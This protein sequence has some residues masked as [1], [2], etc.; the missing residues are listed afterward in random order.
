M[1]QIIHIRND[2]CSKFLKKITVFWYMI[3]SG[4]TI[5]TNISEEHAISNYTKM[6]QVPSNCC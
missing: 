2:N 6:Q 4:K 5:V 3:L 1:G